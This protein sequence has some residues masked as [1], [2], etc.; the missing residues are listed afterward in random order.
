MKSKAFSKKLLI[1]DYIIS[2]LL[3][4]GFLICVAFNGA[5][6]K[7]IYNIMINRGTE[8]SYS[9]IPQLYSLD[10]FGILLAT[11]ITQLGISS[12]AYYLMSR[13]DHKIQLPMQMLNTIPED[14]KEQLDMTQVITT[15]LSTTDN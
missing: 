12:G 9:S 3:M 10:G 11:W 13:S 2:L 8:I 7:E 14:I 15:V 1:A 6:T 5:Y 4:A